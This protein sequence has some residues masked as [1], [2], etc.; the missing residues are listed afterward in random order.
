MFDKK[1]STDSYKGVRDFYPEDMAIQRYIF[2][3]WSKTAESFG[4]ERYDASVLEPAELYK[5][6]GA[7]NEE[8]VKEQTYTFIDRGDR[9]VTLRP[10]MTPTVARMVAGKRRELQFPLRWYSIPNLFRYERPQRGRLREHWQLNCDIFGSDHYTADVEIIALAYQ[11]L[12]DFGAKESDFEI[13]INNRAALNKVYSQFNLTVEGANSTTA[14][15]DR[16]RK[17]SEEEFATA[18]AGA[19][20]T[21]F[22][23]PKETPEEVQ[24]V[25]DA[26]KA[27]DLGNAFYDPSIVR[28]FDYYTGTVFEIFD[29][30]GENNRALLGGGRYDNLTSMFGGEPI[31]GV[32]FGMGDVT[33][34]D[35]L[36]THNLLPARIKETAPTL[37]IIPTDTEHNLAAE[38][39]A[40][41]IRSHGTTV[42]T[43]I[44]TKKLGD[45]ISRAGAR[46]VKYIIVVGETEIAS[47]QFALKNLKLNQEIKGHIEILMQHLSAR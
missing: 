4:F 32:G 25:L 30:S 40:K 24:V 19:A 46:G 23:L 17:M 3:T 38:K 8:M 11:T 37:M 1:L 5:A 31:T 21:D 47:G 43:D 34:R 10:E 33:M 41:E 36:M 6:K 16:K 7:E 42:A 14:V 39:V 13:R 44:G 20:G 22:K 29:T 18:L 35:F 26:L 28:G 2:D 45:K 12:I 27:L 9:E 15:I